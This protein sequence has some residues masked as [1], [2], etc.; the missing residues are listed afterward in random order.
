MRVTWDWLCWNS[1]NVEWGT[2]GNVAALG[3][4]WV[5]KKIFMFTKDHKMIIS[6][7]YYLNYLSSTCWQAEHDC[8]DDHRHNHNRRRP[9]CQ[10]T[11]WPSVADVM[12]HTWRWSTLVSW[13]VKGDYVHFYFKEK[14]NKQKKSTWIQQGKRSI[15]FSLEFLLLLHVHIDSQQ[16]SRGCIDYHSKWIKDLARK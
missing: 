1:S 14:I 16:Q 3:L 6:D 9:L 4:N 12:M 13:I 5:A 7:C 8:T 10:R 2:N 15:K 11:I